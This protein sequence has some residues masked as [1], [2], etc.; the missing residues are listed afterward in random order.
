MS[1]TA[2]ARTAPPIASRPVALAKPASQPQALKTG[3]ASSKAASPDTAGSKPKNLMTSQGFL[4]QHMGTMA[5]SGAGGDDRRPV[6]AKTLNANADTTVYTKEDD[7]SLQR[8]I[9]RRLAMSNTQGTPP[10][11]AEKTSAQNPMTGETMTVFAKDN[12]VV[13]KDG[14]PTGFILAGNP[15]NIW[16]DMKAGMY[17]AARGGGSGGIDRNEMIF[18][19]DTSKPG[20]DYTT[21]SDEQLLQQFNQLQNSQAVDNSKFS[22]SFDL[23]PS[24]DPTG[25]GRY[26]PT[27]NPGGGG[28]SGTS[29]SGGG[30]GGMD[31]S[32]MIFWLRDSNPDVDYTTLSDEQLQQ[33]FNQLQNSQAVDNSNFSGFSDSFDLIPTNVPTGGAR[34]QGEHLTP[35]QRDQMKP[36]A[37]ELRAEGMSL[38]QITEV[39]DVS[40]STVHRW[41]ADVSVP[42]K[43]ARV[44]GVHL[45]PE[46]RDQKG[47]QARELRAQ[48]MNK[49]QI[50][51]VLRVSRPTVRRLLGE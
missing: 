16:P 50:A 35:Q 7:K 9:R 47:P 12:V 39:L 6:D 10:Q 44:L 36:R 28:G 31:K 8:L 15:K 38:K 19:L 40:K 22:D 21:L 5:A 41:T 48:G 17:G 29:T 37:R 27:L 32:E 20:F 14:Q 2:L 42:G 51:E 25:G 33:Q 23:I 26:H 4:S 1:V 18:W 30:S 45:T 11:G 3:E 46:E 34:R 13:D 24:N 43:G 49:T